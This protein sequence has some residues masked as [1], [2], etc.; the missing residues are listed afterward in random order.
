MVSKRLFFSLA[1]FFKV[2]EITILI[3]FVELKEKRHNKCIISFSESL[4]LPVLQ[5]TR[6]QVSNPTNTT[7]HSTAQHITP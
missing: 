5:P 4:P 6:D 7:Q 2:R 1:D 3:I